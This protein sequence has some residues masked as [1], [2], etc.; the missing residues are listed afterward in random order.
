MAFDRLL[1]LMVGSYGACLMALVAFSGRGV[2]GAIQYVLLDGLP[3]AAATILGGA[4]LFYLVRLVSVVRPSSPFQRIARDTRHFFSTPG[5]LL[6][7][8]WLLFLMVLFTSFFSAWKASIPNLNPFSWDPF[9][10]ELDRILHGGTDPWRMTHAIFSGPYFTWAINVVYHLW[11]FVMH[12][13]YVWV[14]MHHANHALRLQYLI[15]FFASWIFVGT[16]T[17]VFFSSAG[18]CYFS[19]VTG[20]ASPYDELMGILTAHDAIAPVW[21]LNVQDILWHNHMQAGSGATSAISAMPSM[22]V[23]STLLFA[24]LVWRLGGRRARGLA[25]AFTL[26]IMIGSVHLG[27]HYAIDGYLAILLVIPVWWLAGK[28]AARRQNRGAVCES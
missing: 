19:K 23:G 14:A 20:M 12:F 7:I 25:I 3:F 5:D 16:A 18:P 21:A 26:S 13:S 22:H 11:F 6:P 2:G 9:F 28:V 24:L 10:F 15:A 8:L 1:P 4:L 27:W 17:A